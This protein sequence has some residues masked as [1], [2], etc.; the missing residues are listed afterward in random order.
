MRPHD[1][2]RNPRPWPYQCY[3]Q[4]A[5]DVSARGRGLLFGGSGLVKKERAWG[6]LKLTVPAQSPCLSGLLL[7]SQSFFP[8]PL[9]RPLH[10]AARNGLASV[11]QALLSRGATV[12]AVDE[13]GRWRLES[14][15]L[16]GLR[17]RPAFR[18]WL[19]NLAINEIV[20][21]IGLCQAGTPTLIPWSLRGEGNE[22]ELNGASKVR[23]IPLPHTHQ[24]SVP[25]AAP[26][27]LHF[28]N[29]PVRLLG[30]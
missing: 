17:P 5:A 21:P 6:S 1:P 25:A 10:I 4:C 15:P 27:R 20:F 23:K 18:G 26:S 28:E 29:L 3:Q 2:G 24:A 8:F 7:A 12:L 11:V 22:V 19:L 14:S 9:P 16:L 30:S 13:E